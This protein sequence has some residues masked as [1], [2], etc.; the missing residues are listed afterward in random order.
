[1]TVPGFE[2]GFSQP[3]GDIKRSPVEKEMSDACVAQLVWAVD[4]EPEDPGSIPGTVESVPFS[5]SNSLN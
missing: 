4:R 5:I 3:L 1:M 2:P